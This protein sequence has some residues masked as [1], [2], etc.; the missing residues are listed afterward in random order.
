MEVYFLDYEC[1]NENEWKTNFDCE[2]I[3]TVM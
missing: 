1:L 2:P 3:E